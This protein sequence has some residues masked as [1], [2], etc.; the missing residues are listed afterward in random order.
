MDMRA[1]LGVFRE[2]AREN[3]DVLDSHLRDLEL[4]SHDAAAVGAMLRSAHTIKGGAAT[5]GVEDVAALAQAVELSLRCLRDHRK[6]LGAS[7]ARQFT[8]SLK[9]LRELVEASGP[10]SAPDAA[11]ISLADELHR[12]VTAS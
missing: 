12:S 8:K 11:V 4:D 3:L 6:P 10:G 5:L 9:L 7:G 1:F 2:E